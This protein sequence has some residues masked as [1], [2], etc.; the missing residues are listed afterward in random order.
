MVF[1]LKE[2]DEVLSISF[3]LKKV[4]TRILYGKIDEKPMINH[5]QSRGNFAP[6]S[7]QK[8]R[9]QDPLKLI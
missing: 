8:T 2:E 4:W 6:G 5:C 7:R 3:S 1:G 9:P